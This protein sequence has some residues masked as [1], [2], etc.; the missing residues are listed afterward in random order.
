[1]PSLRLKKEPRISD[2]DINGLT[3]GG[4][5]TSEARSW[6]VIPPHTAD[7]RQDTAAIFTV[8]G[9]VGGGRVIEGIDLRLAGLISYQGNQ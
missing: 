4:S 6:R 3:D 8:N 9:G 2:R 1:M 7:H 5:Y